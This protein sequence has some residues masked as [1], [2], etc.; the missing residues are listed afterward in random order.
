MDE[1]IARIKPKMISF[2]SDK[3]NNPKL[4]LLESLIGM[5]NIKKP[6]LLNDTERLKNMTD[7]NPALLKLKTKFNLDFD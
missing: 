4:E 3:L 1:F 7:K 6:T 5:E 2:L